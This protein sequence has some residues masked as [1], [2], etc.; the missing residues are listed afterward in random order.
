[1]SHGPRGDAGYRQGEAKFAEAVAAF[2]TDDVDLGK[3]WSD[4]VSFRP[5]T[6][7]RKTAVSRSQ[8]PVLQAES[9]SLHGVAR[10]YAER[11]D[12]S[13]AR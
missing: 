10:S 9:R 1:M 3:T 4:L 2:V 6:F 8:A 7:S 12:V 5:D 11:D 13:D